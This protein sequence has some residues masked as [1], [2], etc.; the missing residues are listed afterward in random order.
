M[1]HYTYGIMEAL[2]K[3]KTTWKKDL[4]F[5]MKLASQKLSKYNAAVTPM[6]GMLLISAHILDAFWKLR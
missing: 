6:M 1:F 2:A 5:T 3:K 4:F